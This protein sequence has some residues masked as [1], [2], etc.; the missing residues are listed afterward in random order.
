MLEGEIS[1]LSAEEQN[2]DIYIQWVS[3]DE[4]SCK[5]KIEID[6]DVIANNVSGYS[7]VVTTFDIV[8]CRNYVVSVTPVSESGREH[9]GET[10]NFEKGIFYDADIIFY[11]CNILFSIDGRISSLK[12]EEIEHDLVIKWTMDS[13]NVCKYVVQSNEVDV[14][15]VLDQYEFS[16]SLNNF[17]S[18]NSYKIR[19]IPISESNIRGTG[20]S[21]SY[22]RGKYT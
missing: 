3:A 5:Y 20:A 21:R 11:T 17:N 12:L 1:S 4:S 10:T 8:L 15:N 13:E 19:V 16:L 9:L 22:H 6:G 18:C 2:G 7:F 14:S